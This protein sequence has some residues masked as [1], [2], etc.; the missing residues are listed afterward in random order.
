MGRRSSAS[1]SGVPFL[2]EKHIEREADLLLAEYGE[3]FEEVV[4]PPIPI[5]EI[6]EIHLQLTFDIADLQQVFGA[7]DIHGAIWINEGRIA[8]DKG[9]DPAANP[10]KLGR[11]RFTLAH[12]TG[13]WRLHRA[14]YLKNTQQRSLFD[15]DGSKRPAECVV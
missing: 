5:D 6:I 8:V 1:R 4:Q 9:L 13:H 3:R 7:G 10:R 2:P 15:S 12:E 11:Y 14:H